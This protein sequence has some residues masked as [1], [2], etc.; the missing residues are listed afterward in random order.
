MTKRLYNFNPGPA[1][2]PLEVLEEAQATFVDYQGNGISLLEMSHRSRGV[3]ELNHETQQLLLQLLNLPTSEYDVLFMGGGASA[4]FALLPMNFLHTNQT[5]HYVLTGS[6]AEKAYKEAT[7]IGQAAIAA[8]SKNQ[9]WSHIPLLDEIQ[10]S[11]NPAYLHL[12]LN[13]TIEGSRFNSIPNVGSTPLVA[14]MTS[15]I[16]SRKLDLQPFSMIYAGA[17]KN[18]G[19][20]GVTVAILRKD[21]LLQGSK[22]IPEIMRYETFAKH[23]SL[24]NTPPVHAIYMMNLMLKWVLQQGGVAALEQQNAGKAKLVYDVIDNSNGFYKGIIAHKDRS[25]M[26]ITWRMADE[27]LEK[28]FI[29]ESLAHGFEG[30]AGHRSVG[31]LRASAYNAVPVEACQA[32]AELMIAFAQ[33]QG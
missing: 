18:L 19:P 10:L 29:Q 2:L 3:E 13:N 15:D 27:A 25:D 31:G 16:L 26:N 23:Q 28:A 8:S 14:D 17:Q 24:F 20:A 7:Y 4:Q 30:L 32:L 21:W 12:T 9:N 5:A 1:A 11:G 33:K 6:F 22:L